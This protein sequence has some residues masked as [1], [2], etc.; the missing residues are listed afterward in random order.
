MSR[1]ADL[2]LEIG[3]ARA[4]GIA[5]AGQ[6][7]GQSVAS[8]GNILRDY[9]QGK[10]QDQELA[11]QQ[12]VRQL[13]ADNVRGEMASRKA[14]DA[15]A[16]TTFANQ[17]TDRATATQQ[18]AHQRHLDNVGAVLIAPP[19]AKQAAWSLVLSQG[20]PADRAGIPEQYPGDEVV[21]TYLAGQ[22]YDLNK[23]RERTQPK[24][25]AV[26]ENGMVAPQPDG[27]YK[28][29]VPP[30]APKAPTSQESKFLL[31]GKPVPGSYLP[32]ANGQPGRYFYNGQ[33][34]TARAGVIPPAAAAASGTGSSDI[35]LAVQGMKEG[36]LPPMLPGR[37]SKEYLATMAEAKRQ[38]YDL[39]SAAT[40]WQATQKHIATL[41]GTQ[42]TRL[43]QSIGALPEL[44]DSVDALAVKWKAGRFPILNKVNLAAAKHG[45]Y[46]RDAATIANQLDA[47]IAD[48]VSDLG[49]VYMGGNSP[50]DHALE[51]ASKSLSA[52]WDATVL[53]DMVTLA[54]QNVTIRQN[55]IRNVGVQGASANNPYAPP[56]AAP[57]GAPMVKPIPGLP[58]AE[59]TSTDGGKTWVRSK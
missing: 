6:A 4:N 20:D 10:L 51:L 46:G 14:D 18:A 53:H 16:A 37:A 13:Q 25:I 50:T 17:Q 3:R 12:Q 28:Q 44:L 7:Y 48:V 55:S 47:Q 21:G 24:P 15:R 9:R 8:L 31:D 58:G 11:A 45:V 32:G 40:D 41:N 19:A 35:A 2:M 59:A 56:P 49:N 36:T 22:G 33:D 5:G 42:Q 23:L 54:K 1:I 38:G 52:N 30:P 27:T 57:Q 39:A 26:G 34:V 43:N 29:V